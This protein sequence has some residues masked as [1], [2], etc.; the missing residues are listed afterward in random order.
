MVST[1]SNVAIVLT[2]S[3]PATP[4]P[5]T[6]LDLSAASSSMTELPCANCVVR[7]D[8]MSVR[9]LAVLAAVRDSTPEMAAST[10]P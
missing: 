9:T 4:A 7:F 3:A 5:I 10:K 2:P 8:E 6:M 1:P